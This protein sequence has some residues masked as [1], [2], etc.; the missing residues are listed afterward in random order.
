MNRDLNRSGLFNFRVILKTAVCS[1]LAC[2][3][4]CASKS[5]SSD[6][7]SVQWAADEV[8]IVRLLV[9][10]TRFEKYPP[11]PPPPDGAVTKLDQPRVAL[12]TTSLSR[13]PRGIV[14]KPAAP[15]IPYSVEA[16]IRMD[17]EGTQWPLD[18][19][20][21]FLHVTSASQAIPDH[22]IRSVLGVSRSAGL[23]NYD[24]L[25]SLSKPALSP[26][27]RKALVYVTHDCGITCGSSKLL[28]LERSGLSWKVAH[29]EVFSQ[30]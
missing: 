6:I 10:P 2:M 16:K 17:H 14:A 20:V 27:G 7:E 5:M 15:C 24:S 19:Q 18:L 21:R 4:G 22:R 13:C 12:L 9:D 1:W 29:S 8:S 30:R 28:L 3:S 11:P 26:D 23:R 25:V